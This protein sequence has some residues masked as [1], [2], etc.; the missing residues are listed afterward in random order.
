MNRIA[1]RTAIATMAMAPALVL[2]GSSAGA[3]PAS[4]PVPV[5]IQEVA[6]GGTPGAWGF[7]NGAVGWVPLVGPLAAFICWV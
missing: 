3:E 6:L 4:A 5:P 7:C 2:V 1:F